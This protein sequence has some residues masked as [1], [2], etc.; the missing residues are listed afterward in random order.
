MSASV[1]ILGSNSALP[2][3]GRHPSAQTLT[4]DQGCFLIDCG[5]GTQMQ[6]LAYKIRRTKID[7]IFIS[8]LHGDHI[9]GL[10]G[11][12]SSY[13][14]FQRTTPLKVYGPTGIKAWIEH[15]ILTT[16]NR[17][18][19]D[20]HIHEF[21]AAASKVLHEI[22]GLTISNVPLEHR[23]PTSGFLFKYE[24]TKR[25]LIPEKLQQYAIPKQVRKNIAAGQDYTLS[26]GQ[27]IPNHELSQL[28]HEKWSYAYLSDTI[29]LPKL[30][31][32]IHGIDLLY[33]EA[34]FLHELL[35]KA[36]MTKHSTAKQAATLA[37]DAQ[38]KQLIIGHF[39]SRYTDLEVLLQEA[40]KEF[41]ETYLG[42]E[43]ITFTI[44]Q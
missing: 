1:T 6:L 38:V 28:K 17:I 40:K 19:F 11:L 29:Y 33:H 26:N 22:K 12:I 44:P 42:I 21:D 20:L 36:E 10:P 16:G 13:N 43:G 4:C 2:L 31:D 23:I 35:E 30:A 8:H 15:S 24:S 39:S 25:N 37:R 34:T 14:H 18:T 7:A 3:H 5:E 9:Y 32:T 41:Q 27:V